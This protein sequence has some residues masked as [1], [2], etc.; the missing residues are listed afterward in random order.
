[1]ARNET[2]TYIQTQSNKH[3]EHLLADKEIILKYKKKEMKKNGGDVWRKKSLTFKSVPLS[4][5]KQQFEVNSPQLRELRIKRLD[6]RG[7]GGGRG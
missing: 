2:T 4:A 7:G 6:Q 5:C 3:S 1:M